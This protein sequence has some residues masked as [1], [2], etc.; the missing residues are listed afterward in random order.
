MVS[1]PPRRITALLVSG[2]GK[3]NINHRHVRALHNHANNPSECATTLKTQAA[4]QYARHRL[5]AHR[6]GEV[7]PGA[8]RRQC[9]FQ[10][11][12]RQ[13]QTVKHRFAKDHWHA[14]QQ[15][16]WALALRMISLCASS[17]SAIF[18][19]RDF[20]AAG[21]LPLIYTRLASR[22]CHLF[23]HQPAP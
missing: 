11:C 5:P 12:G 17:S 15:H 19:A 9:P 10:P 23:Q 13:C 4:V 1:L 8:H 2:T 20:F 21:E 18:P 16:H 6:I 3:Q 14:R 22:Q 7:A